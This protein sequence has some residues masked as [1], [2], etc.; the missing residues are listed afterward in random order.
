MGR[1][2]DMDV[3]RFN[4][5]SS[6]WSWMSNF[7]PGPYE[8]DG[9]WW[10]TVEHYYQAQKTLDENDRGIIRNMSYPWQ[11]KRY[12]KLVKLR[13]D[14]DTVKVDVMEKS[15]RIKFAVGTVLESRLLDTDG[16]VLVHL[17]PWDSFW[18][19]PGFNKL[20]KLLMQIRGDLRD[21]RQHESLLEEPGRDW[22]A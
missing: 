7:H 19:S 12:G 17:S 16:H 1:V 9:L 21:E 13:E 11:A 14:W 6:R 18:G 2:T 10:P 5:D 22:S 20:G 15:L 4:S 3:I 8:I